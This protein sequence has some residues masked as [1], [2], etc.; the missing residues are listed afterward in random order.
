MV[1]IGTS[2][3]LSPLCHSCP[4]D[5]FSSY[6]YFLTAYFTN[7]ANL[8]HKGKH[9]EVAL[10]PCTRLHS[11][12]TSNTTMWICIPME[13]SNLKHELIK[14]KN[15]KLTVHMQMHSIKPVFLILYAD[16]CKWWNK[17][18][19]T[20]LFLEETRKIM[21]NLGSDPDIQDWTLSFLN[22]LVFCTAQYLPSYQVVNEY[23]EI[24]NIQ[25]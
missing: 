2:W 22:G 9:S 19:H 20:A 18:F 12:I 3:D 5:P 15:T 4:P 8:Y 10:V 21:G 24:Y 25:S 6:F 13:T 23:A 17:R 7:L 1:S 11:I 14:I 16:R